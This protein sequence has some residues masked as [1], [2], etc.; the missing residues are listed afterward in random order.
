MLKGSADTIHSTGYAEL[1]AMPATMAPVPAASI[2]RWLSQASAEPPLP[3]EQ[4]L[5]LLERC[6]A[7]RVG[8]LAVHRLAADPRA[9]AAGLQVE[10][11]RYRKAMFF[12]TARVLGGGLRAI[13][14]L[15]AAG[16]PVAGFKGIAAIDWLQDG[17]PER[18]MADI[19]LLVSPAMAEAALAALAAVGFVL[20]VEGVSTAALRAFSRS[21]PGSGGNEAIALCDASGAEIDLHWKVGR[22]DV[23]EVI[24][25][26]VLV[27]VLARRVPLVSSRQALLFSA[28][29]ALRNDFLPSVVVRDLLDAAGWFQRLADHPLEQRLALDEARQTGLEPALGAMACV[30]ADFGIAGGEWLPPSPTTRAL[31]DLFHAQNNGDPINRD[32]VYLCSPLSLLQI[33]RGLCFGGRSY[34]RTMRASEDANGQGG[35]TLRCRLWQLVRSVWSSP[36]GQWRRLRVLAAAKAQ[37]N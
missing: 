32:L 34:L 16:V 26:A 28:Q 3:P 22:V 15:T 1:N 33:V 8:P 10:L 36:R 2:L 37:L 18:D 31:A 12:R 23:A 4:W 27:P 20:K 13:E 24:N 19:D 25:A 9:G 21:S 7:L 5:I 6:R 14:A 29:H 30:L 17:R 35:M 11:D